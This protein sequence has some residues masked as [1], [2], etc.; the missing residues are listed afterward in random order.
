MAAHQLAREI[1]TPACARACLHCVLALAAEDRPSMLPENA[2]TQHATGSPDLQ[3]P[4][5]GF[6]LRNTR[7]RPRLTCTVARGPRD[8]RRSLPEEENTPQASKT[9]R[10]RTKRQT[11]EPER[12][13]VAGLPDGRATPPHA[14]PPTRCLLGD[15][16]VPP[17]R[18]RRRPCSEPHDS[19]CCRC[20]APRRLCTSLPPSRARRADQGLGQRDCRRLRPLESEL[21]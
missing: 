8:S 2:T 3:K 18:T 11:S 15:V 17:W 1:I 7:K 5:G 6:L 10:A 14:L 9:Q 19:S 21:P 16:T 13:R 20:A 4:G 12:R